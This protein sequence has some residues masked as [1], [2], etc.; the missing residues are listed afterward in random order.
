MLPGGFPMG[1]LNYTLTP[2]SARLGP[3][4]DQTPFQ[5]LLVGDAQARPDGLERFLVRG[6][7]QVTEAAYPLPALDRAAQHPPDLVIFPAGSPDPRPAG[8]GR[9]PAA[10]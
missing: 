4:P 7:F 6:G 10:T 5:I 1:D 3:L 9:G 8:G 2:S